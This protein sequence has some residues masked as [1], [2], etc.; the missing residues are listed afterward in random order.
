M[1]DS[2]INKPLAGSPV[3]Q[4]LK[5]GDYVNV[6]G[7]EQSPGDVNGIFE[8]IVLPELR[9]Q[10]DPRVLE[11][12]DM[13]MK[14]EADAASKTHLSFEVDK[15]NTVRRPALLWK[16]AAELVLL[17]QKNKAM[18]DMLGIIKAHPTHP[19][20]ATWLAEL[21]RLVSPAPPVPVAAPAAAAPPPALGAAPGGAAP[22]P[23]VQ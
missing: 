9:T 4:W 18:S 21:E 13:R 20:A 8:K 19:E 7:W 16:R 15:Y 12:W 3:V 23:V 14:R 11:Y 22:A 1:H 17:G 10:K 6:Q 2:I 5:L